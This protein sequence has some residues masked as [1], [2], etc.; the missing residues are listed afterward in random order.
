VVQMMKTIDGYSV[1]TGIAMGIASR[2]GGNFDNLVPSIKDSIKKLT[3]MRIPPDVSGST[4]DNRTGLPRAVKNVV[5]KSKEDAHEL[6][7]GLPSHGAAPSMAGLIQN[8]VKQ[9]STALTELGSTL[10]SSILSQLTGQL[11][12]VGNLLNLLSD[13]QKEELDNA[14]PPDISAALNNLMTLKQTEQGGGLPGNFMLGGIVN[15]ATFLPKML[16]KLK[17]VTN[18]GQLDSVINEITHSAF[19]SD[20]LEGLEAITMKIEGLFGGIEKSISPLGEITDLLSEAYEFFESLF[21]GLVGELPA[22]GTRMFGSDSQ[23]PDLMKRMKT[24]DIIGAV[25][26]NLENK[27]P[28]KN[29]TRGKITNGG[30]AGTTVGSEGWF[31]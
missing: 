18:F 28:T 17:N 30:S 20:A 11:F 19:E 21:S 13:D 6:Y 25:K 1:L 26:S 23:I 5:E 14:L 10:N 2:A 9:V 27:H 8:P 7:D 4:E 22:A 16:T 15:P 29:E 24:D 12:S 3:G 31:A